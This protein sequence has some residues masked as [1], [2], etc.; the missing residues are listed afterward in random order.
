MTD[1][2]AELL[3]DFT[4]TQPAPIADSPAVV[5]EELL[6]QIVKHMTEHPRSQQTRIGPSEIGN[7]CSRALA[8]AIHEDPE[9]ER[10]P[11]WKAQIGTWAHAGFEQV[12]T[13]SIYNHRTGPDGC[14]EFPCPGKGPGHKPRYL[15]EQK[16]VVGQ[17]GGQDIGGSC[18]L[19]DVET[20]T[21]VDWKSKGKRTLQEHKRHGPGE[22]YR[23]QA[24]L[25]GRGWQL[26]GYRVRTVMDVFFPRDGELSEAFP[27]SE[28]YDEQVAI[29]ALDRC[30]QL[31]SL[32]TLVGIDAA[33]AMYPECDDPWCSWCRPARALDARTGHGAPPKAPR[34]LGAFRKSA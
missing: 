24:H 16:V 22:K 29:T 26:R 11:N 8:H 23:I 5:W 27:W 31:H 28:P 13:E 15:L 12:F 7:T 25:Y 9:P 3:K 1:L 20:G 33:L 21:V 4:F 2:Q 14:F 6:D 32:I 17:I 34:Q 10:G 19:F 18:D 30:N